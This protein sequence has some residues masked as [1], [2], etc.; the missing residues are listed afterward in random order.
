MHLK[1]SKAAH[2]IASCF[3]Q[4]DEPKKKASK[5]TI[6]WKHKHHTHISRSARA[7]RTVDVEK[8]TLN[9]EI[10]SFI[11]VFQL[12]N[13]KN[14]SR[15]NE[16]SFCTNLRH[17]TCLCATTVIFVRKTF[18]LAPNE[19]QHFY[20]SMP[21][22]SI[23]FIFRFNQLYFFFCFAVATDLDRQIEFVQLP[24]FSRY[25][26]ILFTH[27]HPQLS[28]A[29]LQ[30]K[31]KHHQQQQQRNCHFLA[32]F[33][34]SYEI[35]YVWLVVFLSALISWCISWQ[36]GE[37]SA[38]GQFFFCDCCINWMHV[39]TPKIDNLFLNINERLTRPSKRLA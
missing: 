30:Q 36:V 17:Q 7:P 14:I 12:N 6:Q 25:A 23:I 2:R 31:N 3:H 39:H 1:K 33:P 5:P 28:R 38:S 21:F 11:V 35:K 29:N 34:I 19:M 24:Q 15:E 27:N 4:V 22:F 26:A 20:F 8:W 16:P 32:S 37:V 13:L 10:N 18:Q 9:R